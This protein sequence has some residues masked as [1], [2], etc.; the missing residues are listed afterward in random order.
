MQPRTHFGLTQ[1]TLQHCVQSA[2]NNQLTGTMIASM[3]EI[4]SNMKNHSNVSSI[5]TDSLLKQRLLHYISK[6]SS[7]PP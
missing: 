7:A 5:S 2:L 3:A 6:I 4:I 1:L